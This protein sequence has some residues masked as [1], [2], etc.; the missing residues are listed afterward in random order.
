MIYPWVRKSLEIFPSCRRREL[1]AGKEG[2]GIQRLEQTVA[3]AVHDT[4]LG[5]SKAE[6]AL[7]EA[8]AVLESF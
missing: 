6:A 1:P 5:R 2:T 3:K 8:A 7:K 4:I